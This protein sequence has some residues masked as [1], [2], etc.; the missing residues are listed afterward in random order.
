MDSK[1]GEERVA[2]GKILIGLE[3]DPKH[4][5]LNSVKRDDIRL[6]KRAG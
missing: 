3:M 6:A 4:R 5:R 1:R 2:D